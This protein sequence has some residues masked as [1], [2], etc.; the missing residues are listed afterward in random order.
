MAL[1]SAL[2]DRPLIGGTVLCGEIG[3]TGELRPIHGLGRR[4]REAAR[5]GFTRAIVPQQQS[6][7]EPLED[8]NGI[9][10][11]RVATLRDAISSALS[12]TQ[13]RAVRETVPIV[14]G[15]TTT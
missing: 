12:E 4:L 3:L 15:E 2:R 5:L 1:A 11:V 10:L 6:R 14:I 8:V 13:Q 7:R 9:E